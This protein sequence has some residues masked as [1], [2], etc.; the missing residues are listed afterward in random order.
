MHQFSLQ[1]LLTIC[2]NLFRAKCKSCSVMSPIPSFHLKFFSPSAAGNIF[3]GLFVSVSCFLS[4]SK[5]TKFCRTPFTDWSLLLHDCHFWVQQL[6]ERR[7]LTT[8][9][10]LRD[11]LHISNKQP[12]YLALKDAWNIYAVSSPSV[13]VWQHICLGWGTG[14]CQSLFSNQLQLYFF[15]MFI[16]D[17]QLTYSNFRGYVLGGFT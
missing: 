17:W 3:F 6:P 7:A 13:D 9:S 2:H 11:P 16:T 5:L 14:V 1:R 4:P 8:F 12:V 10:F 15:D